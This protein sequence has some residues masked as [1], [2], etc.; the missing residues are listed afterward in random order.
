MLEGKEPPGER[1]VVT[2][3]EG[4]F[5][6]W[7]DLAKPLDGDDH[8]HDAD[9]E[10]HGLP[11]R[12]AEP[13]PIVQGKAP[14]RVPTGPTAWMTPVYPLLLAGVF[15]LFGTFPFSAYLAAGLVD[16]FFPTMV[17]LPP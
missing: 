1:V 2:D 14:F 16:L 7:I 12:G 9:V 11:A 15:R 13:P 6:E 8:W 10:L 4:F 17:F 5:R 3:A